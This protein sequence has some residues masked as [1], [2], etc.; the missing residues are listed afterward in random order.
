[1][2]QISLKKMILKGEVKHI[3]RSMLDNS[4]DSIS[5]QDENG[6]LLVENLTGNITGNSAENIA[7]P[8]RSLQKEAISTPDASKLDENLE[9]QPS[10]LHKQAIEVSG[11]V[12]GWV[13]GTASTRVDA[14]VI[15][16]T[17]LATREIERKTLAA[18][19][20]DKYREINFLY[21]ISGRM[22]SCLGIREVSDLV[23]EEAR[24]LIEATSASVMLLN[25]DTDLLEIVSGVGTASKN[26]LELRLGEGIAGYVLKTGKA[27][28]VND[29][30]TD[31]RYIPSDSPAYALICAPLRTKDKTIGVINISNTNPVNYTSED[32][33]LFTALTAQASAAIENALLHE[34]KLKEERIKNNLER[35][36][37]PQVVQAVIGAKG[38]VSLNTTKRNLTMLFSDIRG[39]T[40]KCEELAP[41]EVV[42]YLN[43][44]FTH[45]VSVIFSHR[46]TVNK[47][48]GDMIV[49]MFGAPS[50][51]LDHER[52]AIETAIE[53]QKRIR[54]IPVPWIRE[55]FITGIGIS[56]GDVVVGNIGS[57]QHMDYTAI[58]DEVNIASRLQSIAL[59]GQILV[60]RGVYEATKDS[61]EF[62]E[63][64]I[65]Q[66]KGKKKAIE[67]FEV[68]H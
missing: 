67:V 19:A 30:S 51:L 22:A 39:F 12:V 8:I 46:G 23:I 1:M 25:E 50:R 68:I 36:L 17:H 21:N 16:L 5:I 59:G 60:S 45:M 58:G 38:E 7:N 41:E 31:P 14:V 6:N 29:L 9:L 26:V 34:N 63:Y 43:E 49:A 44:Y 64:G 52:R 32:L 27:E 61:F 66:V 24:K 62:K 35:Y 53:M 18:E 65:V 11:E 20:L 4:S 28:I 40:T 37:S 54:T 42:M 57:P 48:V 56:T 13:T 33:K 15:L 10:Q 55:N 47:F 3:V 2:A